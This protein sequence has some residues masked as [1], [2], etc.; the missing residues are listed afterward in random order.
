VNHPT[1]IV[2]SKKEPLKIEIPSIPTWTGFD[3]IIDFLVQEYNALILEKNEDPFERAWILEIN[4]KKIELIHGDWDGNYL[5]AS[6]EGEAIIL[7]IGEVLEERL[8]GD[9]FEIDTTIQ[10]RIY[11]TRE[12]AILTFWHDNQDLTG[13]IYKALQNQASNL[14]EVQLFGAPLSYDLFILP[15]KGVDKLLKAI[16]IMDKSDLKTPL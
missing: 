9:V 7:E 16:K 3:E 13:K 1:K 10:G 6:E 12:G 11:K 4:K 5:Q 2:R 14:K 8:M 15:L